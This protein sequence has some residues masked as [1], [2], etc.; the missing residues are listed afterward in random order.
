MLCWD[1]GLCF[2]RYINMYIR[3]QLIGRNQDKAENWR[4]C[5]HAMTLALTNPCLFATVN[6]NNNN[7]HTPLLC[8]S[9]WAGN[10]GNRFPMLLDII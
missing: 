10:V 6:N 5:P 3:N 2:I 9:V 4:A 8:F 1:A 7:T